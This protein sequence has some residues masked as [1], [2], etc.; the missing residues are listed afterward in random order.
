MAV[1]LAVKIGKDCKVEKVVKKNSAGVEKTDVVIIDPNTVMPDGT[2]DSNSI[3][4]LNSIL[5]RCAEMILDLGD[6]EYNP[7]AYIINRL[8]FVYTYYQNPTAATND[9]STL[10][11]IFKLNV[12]HVFIP[13]IDN[14]II[15]L[16]Q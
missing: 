6:E 4:I 13:S 14:V 5:N 12:F 7:F 15:E 3:G 2:Y 9:I 1:R 8:D 16:L 10:T 11:S